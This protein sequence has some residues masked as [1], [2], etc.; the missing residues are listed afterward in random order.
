MLDCGRGARRVGSTENQFQY[1]LFISRW[2]GGVLNLLGFFLVRQFLLAMGANRSEDLNKS[3]NLHC[4]KSRT[5][6]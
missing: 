1:W 5:V 6:M 4:L 3:N 2:K